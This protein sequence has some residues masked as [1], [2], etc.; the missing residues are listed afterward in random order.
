MHARNARS[1][2]LWKVP[3]LALDGILRWRNRPHITGMAKEHP[4]AEATFRVVPQEDLT[5]GVEVQ[6]PGSFPVMVTSFATERAA[7]TWITDYKRRVTENVP[8]RF[9]R[10]RASRD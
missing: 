2:S 10:V 9:M 3:H 6:V 5:F 7:E 4:H 1:T 8:Y